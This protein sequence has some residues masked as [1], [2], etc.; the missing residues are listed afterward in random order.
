MATMPWLTMVAGTDSE[1]YTWNNSGLN[2]HAEQKGKKKIQHKVVMVQRYQPSISP[3]SPSSP[4]TLSKQI[5][6]HDA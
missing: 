4:S 3:S 5:N 2:K 6:C 1:S